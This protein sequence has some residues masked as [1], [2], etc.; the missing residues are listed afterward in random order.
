MAWQQIY[1]SAERGLVAGRSGFC[2]VARHREIPE[3]LSSE[4]ERLCRYDRAGNT[5]AQGSAG[6]P[7]IYCYR[8]L[9]SGRSTYHVL[10]RIG[11]CGSDYTGRTNFLAHHLV[12]DGAEIEGVVS[13]AEILMQMEWRDSWNERAPRYLTADEVVDLSQFNG[14][15]SLPARVWEGATGDAGNAALPLDGGGSCSLIYRPDG[16]Q[17]KLLPI[18]AETLLLRT[19]KLSRGSGLWGLGF[20]SYLQGSDSS[21][22]F[23]IYGGWEGSRVHIEAVRGGARV[24]DLT[25]PIEAASGSLADFARSGVPAPT[26]VEIPVPT[27]LVP[28]TAITQ[29]DAPRERM[30]S[31]APKGNGDLVIDALIQ[32][33]ENRHGGRA[34]ASRSRIKFAIAGALGIVL[35]GAVLLLLP[36]LKQG[37]S[38]GAAGMTDNEKSAEVEKYAKELADLRKEG[39]YV[40]ATSLADGWEKKDKDF[41]HVENFPRFENEVKRVRFAKRLDDLTRSDDA[42][43]RLEKL[44]QDKNF[45]EVFDGDKLLEKQVIVANQVIKFREDLKTLTKAED[46]AGM[47]LILASFPEDLGA[48]LGRDLGQR[49][50]QLLTSEEL[51][52]SGAAT[53]GVDPGSRP[54]KPPAP[55]PGQE[56]FLSIKTYLVIL[57]SGKG[58][59]PK[60]LGTGKKAEVAMKFNP[61]SGAPTYGKSAD[62]ENPKNLWERWSPPVQSPFDW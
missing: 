61:G 29:N 43:S 19:P 35:I 23:Q 56:N 13:P 38:T 1:T 51:V 36:R 9:Q 50:K 53:P 21:S 22:D 16:D 47:R 55:S 12:C 41:K 52:D 57:H 37:E 15:V 54:K 18:I 46:V 58:K 14:G 28:P 5:S 3:F 27:A 2:T 10:S 25:K 4:I 26:A 59:V 7:T 49:E 6:L 40:K 31:S 44:Q 34:R 8:I 20:T 45:K 39:E 33:A 11:D 17:E 24:V 42:T 32:K 48:N 62:V 60:G 30:L